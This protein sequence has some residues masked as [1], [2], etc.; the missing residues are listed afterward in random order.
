MTQ[1]NKD[2]L[3]RRLQSL[4]WRLGSLLALTLVN[5]LAANLDLFNLQPGVVVILSLVL[6]EIT[7]AISNLSR[8]VK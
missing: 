1:E 8:D 2:L 4:A 7:K 5:F 3:V 6:S